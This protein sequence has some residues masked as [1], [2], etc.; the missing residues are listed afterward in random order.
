MSTN[1]NVKLRLRGKAIKYRK[2]LSTDAEVYCDTASAVQ[3]GVNYNPGT[4]LADEEWFRIRNISAQPYAIEVL[5]PD[6]QSVDYDLL[7]RDEFSSIDYLFVCSE[8]TI[9]FQN[10]GKT[11]LLAKKRI[12]SVG[13]DFCYR[14]D[15][16]EIV[17][18][19][20]PDAIYERKT[21]SLFFKRL[22]AV[23]GIF[24]GIDQLYREATDEETKS[25][26]ENDFI[27][28][29]DDFSAGNVKTPNRKRIALALSALS[30]IEEDDK[31]AMFSYIGEYCPKLKIQD[32]AF[33]IGNEDELKLLLYGI[34]QRFYTTPIGGEK[35]IANSVLPISEGGKE[36]G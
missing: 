32:E 36:N 33:S 27:Q 30:K 28:L 22:E 19:E 15:C 2:M 4:L 3:S 35:R 21:D 18:N 14:S 24:K 26:L 10:I 1:V 12:L 34:E 13:E 11:K 5:S 16:D 23:T 6:N 8:E 7:K 17:L 29:R 20:V 25:F 9:C 31:K